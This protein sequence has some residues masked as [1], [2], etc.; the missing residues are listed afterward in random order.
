MPSF[1]Y[2]DVSL[3]HASGKNLC[4][5]TIQAYVYMVCFNNIATPQTLVVVLACNGNSFT[6]T[7]TLG[8]HARPLWYACVCMQKPRNCSS[9][10]GVLPSS[11]K[12]WS[13]I[14]P[15]MTA[16]T[17]FGA[18]HRKHL[19]N[20]CQP[21]ESQCTPDLCTSLV[22]L[23]AYPTSHMFSVVLIKTADFRGVNLEW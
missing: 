6:I 4:R 15:T 19:L 18:L 17:P 1:D 12:L 2:G 20:R 14:A 7:L 22:S 3:K 10:A 9:T 8:A 11:W 16:T 13:G 21:I 5:L 23:K